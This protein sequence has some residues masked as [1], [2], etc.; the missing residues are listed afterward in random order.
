[1]STHEMI[2]SVRQRLRHLKSALRLI[3]QSSPG[4]TIASL[5]LFIVQGVLPLLSLYLLKLVVD[6]AASVDIATAYEG[7]AFGKV[8]FLI[9]LAGVVSILAA[10]LQ[11]ITKWV[12]EAQ[13]YQVADYVYDILHAK[14]I[15]VDL[16]CY[17]N[18]QYYDK[19]HRAEK[20]GPKRTFQ[21]I[22]N[23]ENLSKNGIS[24]L[25]MLGLLV[26]FHW[27]VAVIL[28]MAAIP[29]L[30]V[31]LKYTDKM[32]RWQ[33][34]RTTAERH[35]WYFSQV[36]TGDKY[37]KEIRLLGFSMENIV[38]IIGDLIDLRFVDPFSY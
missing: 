25:A 9:A 15:E 31:K 38:H 19:L 20:E 6:A 26:S 36:L 32:Y 37:A 34:K 16:A 22:H 28:L 29:G 12:H 14:T 27:G 35:C 23:L 2:N 3:W 30:I 17:E 5:I 24:L 10:L 7:G 1:M 8:A 33:R 21:I 13:I 18:S 4:W 11:S